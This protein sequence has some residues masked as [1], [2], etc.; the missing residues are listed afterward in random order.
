MSP[1]Y[2][3]VDSLPIHFKPGPH[4]SQSFLKYRHNAA[5]MGGPYIHEQVAATA[6]N[7]SSFNWDFLIL[8]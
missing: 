6:A 7:E 1:W 8:K 5:V 2:R 3:G 4:V